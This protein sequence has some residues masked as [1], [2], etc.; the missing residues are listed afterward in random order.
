M[1]V[2]CSQFGADHDMLI[3]S[4]APEVI[5]DWEL[6]AVAQ[7]D[8]CLA[9]AD[10]VTG[11]RLLSIC[12]PITIK[13]AFYMPLFRNRSRTLLSLNISA[14]YKISGGLHLP[15][16]LKLRI[17]LKST[18]KNH[19]SLRDG[20]VSRAAPQL[21]DLDVDVD[22]GG[23]D[24]AA[25][26]ARVFSFEGMLKLKRVAVPPHERWLDAI[27]SAVKHGAAFDGLQFHQIRKIHAFTNSMLAA[28]MS[29]AQLT[30]W[31]NRLVGCG[32]SLQTFQLIGSASLDLFFKTGDDLAPLEKMG[33][34]VGKLLAEGGRAFFANLPELKGGGRS[35]DIDTWRELWALNRAKDVVS[36]KDADADAA[37]DK[38][39]PCPRPKMLAEAVS[40][41]RS[42][43]EDEEAGS[44]W[45]AAVQGRV[46]ERDEC[47]GAG[48]SKHAKV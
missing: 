44:V 12:G 38:C 21:V 5:L 19:R 32:A 18:T 1:Q 31:I 35:Q 8:A 43:C 40:A 7:S 2:T 6:A 30:G 25:L 26:C 41:T 28:A 14:V 47:S 15:H 29:V 27:V 34:A 10:I 16:L 22:G 46:R 36:S 33:E 39:D 23:P 20:C 3:R 11:A 9:T 4:R 42:A 24:F 45:V 37:W 17:T 13:G 48:P